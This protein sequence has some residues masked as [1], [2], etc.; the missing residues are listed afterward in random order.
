MHLGQHRVRFGLGEESAALDR[1]QLRRI[2]QHQ[3]RRAERQQVAAELG[4]DHRA[5][6]DHDQL[7]LGGGGIVPQFEIRLLLAGFAGA[8][9]Q[10][11]NGG[12]TVAAPAAHHQRG[13]AGERGVFHVAVDTV[14]DVPGQGG[15][16]GAGI[17]E[18]AEH[19][20]CAAFARL[21]LDPVGHGVQ[22]SILVRSECGH[23]PKAEWYKD[24][25]S[26]VHT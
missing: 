12:G 25:T 17:T 14:G 2:A 11:V 19:L 9:D 18:Q 24:R 3:Q 23:D 26:R 21:G 10:R 6:V 20:R 4:I 22:R 1:R 15:L 8:V 5:L 7:G 13:F 16:A